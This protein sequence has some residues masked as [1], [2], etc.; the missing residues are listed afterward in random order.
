MMTDAEGRWMAF[1][2]VPTTMVILEKKSRRT[3][4]KVGKL[5]CGSDCAKPS[6]RLARSWRSYLDV[7]VIQMFAHGT[8]LESN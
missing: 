8:N 7:K 5:G 6:Q 4:D 3:F 2:L 1:N